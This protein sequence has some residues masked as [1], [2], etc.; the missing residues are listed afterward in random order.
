MAALYTDQ[1]FSLLLRQ[2]LQWPADMQDLPRGQQPGRPAFP[3]RMYRDPGDYSPQ[4]PGALAVIFKHQLLWTLPLQVCSGAQTQ[5]IGGGQYMGHVLKSLALMSKWCLFL[6]RHHKAFAAPPKQAVSFGLGKMRAEAQGKGRS[7]KT[8]I[9][10]QIKTRRRM[11]LMGLL[12]CKCEWRFGEQCAANPQYTSRL[13]EYGREVTVSVECETSLG[14]QHIKYR[15]RIFF[16]LAFER[17]VT[18]GGALET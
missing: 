9:L 14:I 7:R 5:A 16:F 10:N 11:G 4:L 1:Q 15:S 13:G 3:L 12:H 6:C 8:F 18:N 2:P 17:E